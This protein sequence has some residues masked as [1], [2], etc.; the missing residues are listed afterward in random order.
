[1]EGK[2]TFIFIEAKGPGV[3]PRKKGSGQVHDLRDIAKWC[4]E[5][6]APGKRCAE[7]SPISQL[8]QY[9]CKAKSKYLILSTGLYSWFLVHALDDEKG[10]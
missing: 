3:Y 9:G 6:E 2:G 7:Q 1:M 8:Y 4:R 5:N 10:A